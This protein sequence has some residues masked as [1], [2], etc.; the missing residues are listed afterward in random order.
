MKETRHVMAEQLKLII[1]AFRTTLPWKYSN[2]HIS[3]NKKT[4]WKG[5][6]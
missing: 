2:K 3:R 6:I 4:A 1:R 5:S